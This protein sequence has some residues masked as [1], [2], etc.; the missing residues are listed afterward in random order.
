[1]AYLP[2]D[3]KL[4][5]L[6]SLLLIRVQPARGHWH[7]LIRALFRRSPAPSSP[8]MHVRDPA[9]AALTG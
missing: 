3:Y 8:V 6:Q 9:H 7:M 2:Y 1:M 4:V 5:L